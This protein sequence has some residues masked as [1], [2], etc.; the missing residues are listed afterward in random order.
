MCK[1]FFLTCKRFEAQ[2]HVVQYCSPLSPEYHF[3]HPED[4]AKCFLPTNI[5]EGS[6]S[7]PLM[8]DSDP[9]FKHSTTPGTS[10]SQNP[11]EVSYQTELRLKRKDGKFRWFLVKCIS[12][13]VV[14]QGRKWFGTC[15]DINDHKLLEQKLKEAHDAAQKSTES[16]TRFLSNMSHGKLTELLFRKC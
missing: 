5:S 2:W 8:S 15:T 7:P 11:G 9:M 6:G 14:E 16:K 4:R 10:T 1:F 13:E 12:V 3:S